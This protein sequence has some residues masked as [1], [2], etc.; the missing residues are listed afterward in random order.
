MPLGCSVSSAAWVK[1]STFIKW[2]VQKEAKKGLSMHYLD[3][4][5]FVGAQGSGDCSTLLEVFHKTSQ[6][7]GVPIAHE[8]TEGPVT[9]IVFLGLK[10]DTKNQT[11]TIPAEKLEEMMQKIRAVLKLSKVTLKQL[12]S[13]IG[14]LNF[15]CWP[16]APGRAFL[17]QLIGST[18]PLKAPHHVTR[19]NKQIKG[20]L[21]MWLEFLE[22][23]N[24]ISVFRNQIRLKNEDM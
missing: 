22:K 12:L 8:K 17:R 19:V 9:E 15:A 3:D 6:H 18:I 1:F 13:L 2:L 11:V 10:I 24:G 14:S 23:Y 4:Y 7:L 16:V 21:C 20:D 5:L